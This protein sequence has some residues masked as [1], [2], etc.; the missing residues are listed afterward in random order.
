T[1]GLFPNPIAVN[2]PPPPAPP[3]PTFFQIPEPPQIASI[4]VNEGRL[5]RVVL[6]LDL[7]ASLVRRSEF[8]EIH[9]TLYISSVL[10]Y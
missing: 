4:Q 6:T 8:F 7:D 1:R 3:T 2:P 10:N 9:P 5:T